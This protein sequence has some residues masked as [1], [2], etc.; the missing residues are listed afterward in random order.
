MRYPADIA[1]F[2]A[3]ARDAEPVGDAFDA[4]LAADEAAYVL[5]VM[6]TLP[7]HW[8]LEAPARLAQMVCMAAVDDVDAHDIVALDDTHAGDVLELSALVYPHYFRQRTTAL[9]RYFGL[10]EEGR[11]AAMIGE[12]MATDAWQ[13]ISAVCTHPDHLGRGHARRLLAWLSN[14][15]H[16]QGRTPFLH[17]SARN[18]RAMEVYARTGYVVRRE[19]SFSAIRRR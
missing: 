11:L 17:V 9:G 3:V 1:P 4:L 18:T 8:Q 10:Y 7:A 6:P 15:V 16:A 12:R 14:D 5:G 13:E 19:I 2:V